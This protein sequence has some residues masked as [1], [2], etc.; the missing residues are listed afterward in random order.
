MDIDKILL[1]DDEEGIRR[2][3]GIS[4][5]DMG[6]QVLT[7]EDGQQALDIFSREQPPIVLTDIKM[8]GMDGIE[9]LRRIKRQNPNTEVIVITGHGDMDLAIKSLKYEAT[10]FITK[11]INDDELAKALQ[12]SKKN[13]FLRLKL[14]EY[15][16]NLEK[17]VRDKSERLAAAGLTQEEILTSKKYEHLFDQMPGYVAVLDKNNRLLAA[18]LQF[19]QDFQFTADEN[20]F[21]YKI[22]KG[23]EN[24]CSDCPVQKTFENGKAQHSD[25]QYTT[26]AGAQY[27]VLIWTAPL[28]DAAGNT[29]RVMLMATDITQVL[30]LQDHLASLG[31]MIG[32][33]S[34]GIKGLLTGLDGGV[35][36]LDSGFSKDDPAKMNEGL[37]VVKLMVGRI[38]SMVLDILYYTKERDLNKKPVETV[39]ICRDVAKIVEPKMRSLK[40]DLIK[41]FESVP[42]KWV[43]DADRDQLQTALVNIVDNAIDACAEDRNKAFHQ[44]VISVTDENNQ[45][46]IA[47]EDNGIGM[48]PEIQEKIFTLFF[49][50]KATKGTGIG[51]FVTSKI[52]KQHNGTIEVD[53]RP[54]EGTC[55]RI[56]LPLLKKL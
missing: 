37:D 43:I 3:L 36:L 4:L 13:I 1:V 7:A 50:S 29:S 6:Y 15:T 33:V 44:I 49:S 42:K 8:P 5:A 14:N 21:C 24:P 35:Y 45:V 9:V 16:E 31:L 22:L 47:I 30:D 52:V 10:D 18:N 39:E 41:N 51:L 2:V 17:L 55:F 54:G 25:M 56:T 48:A 27:N 19:K 32:S 23:S 28:R 53:S 12:K 26:R 40:I 11:P 38:K 46:K 20:A 34:H